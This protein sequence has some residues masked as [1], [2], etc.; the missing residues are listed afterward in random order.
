MAEHENPVGQ[1]RVS[2]NPIEL[3]LARVA[4]QS[5]V[6]PQPDPPPKPPG[7]TTVAV[8]GGG[9]AGL[10]AALRLAQRG[11]KVTVYEQKPELGGNFAAHKHEHPPSENKAERPD[12]YHEHSFH[13]ILEWYHNFFALAADI[14]LQRHR[15]FEPRNTFKHLR[16][17]EF[18][19]MID[20]RN[21]G[22]PGGL[23]ANLLC[24]LQPIPDMFLYSYS[25]IDLISQRFDPNRML[26]RF[27]VTG[28]MQSRPYATEGSTALHENTLAK[29][30]ASPSYLTSACSYQSFI[31]YGFRHPEPLVWVLKGDSYRS[32]HAKL[33]AEL[34]RLGCKVRLLRQVTKIDVS[35]PY[36]TPSP[37]PGQIP[38]WPETR[39]KRVINIAHK[40][41]TKREVTDCVLFPPNAP[42][43]GAVRSL[44]EAQQPPPSLPSFD[45]EELAPEATDQPDYVVLAVPPDQVARLLLVP[46]AKDFNVLRLLS[47]DFLEVAKIPRLRGAPMASLDLHFN[48]KIEGIPKEHVALLDA[49]FDISFIDNSQIWP[50]LEKTTLLNVVAGS[51]AEL[52]QLNPGE[53]AGLII[54]ELAKFLEF[55]PAKDIDWELCHYQPNVGDSLFLNDVGSELWRPAAKT[56][57]RNLFLAGDYCRTF[58]DV[59][60]LEG[61]V[62]SGLEAARQ[63]QEQATADGGWSASDRRA[64]PIGIIPIETPE[65]ETVLA[66]KF[67]LA[68]H[69]MAAK[70]WS[71]ADEQTRGVQRGDFSATRAAQDLTAMGTALA[72]APYRFAADA[73]T[74]GWST[75]LSLWSGGD[76]D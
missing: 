17:G 3:A 69:A 26:D 53:A 41:V 6:A 47:G 39:D 2:P 76:L 50:G 11:Y 27:S 72:L 14:G 64:S 18:P 55:D 7:E 1:G 10:T 30:F 66:L 40:A 42:L 70:W 19:T 24:G 54:L 9:I 12:T 35:V 5:R 8:I 60:T 65:P 4:E 44:V 67:L 62:V 13:M 38:P 16:M 25:L 58:V 63:L 61:A 68:P 45:E 37:L 43:V 31:K 51:A 52:A 46:A 34:V 20:L 59:V 57:F 75:M 28:F 22:S 29:A 73:W 36:W 71:W 23:Q 32:F 49:K 48:R 33:H 74:A 21:P 15:D 56:H